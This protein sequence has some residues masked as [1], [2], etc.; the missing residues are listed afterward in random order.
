[1][2]VFKIALSLVLFM[3]I[4]TSA[5]AL[6]RNMI[7]IVPT[8]QSLDVVCENNA[9]ANVVQNSAIVT[10]SC[11][12]IVLPTA[13]PVV[14]ADTPT[15]IAP[16]NT[17]TPLPVIATDT[18]TP[19]PTNT[20]IPATATETPTLTSTPVIVLPSP[21]ATQ[22]A[23]SL[24]QYP[25]CGFHDSNVWHGL[26]DY[27]NQCH[28]NHTHDVNPNA[29]QTTNMI[30]NSA[31]GR[32]W[33]NIESYTGKQI[34]YIWQTTNENL[35]K[36]EG[37]HIA[38]AINLPCEQQNYLYLPE[39]ARNCISAFRGVFHSANATVDGVS[40]FHSYSAE[41]V[42]KDRLTGQIG[43]FA[44]GGIGDTDDAHAPYKTTCVNILGAN[45][46]PC[47]DNNTVWLN[48][49][50]NPPYWAFTVKNTALANL[51][52]GYLCRTSA[53]ES[54]PSNKM[55][56]EN[57]SFDRTDTLGNRMGAANHIFHMNAR[58]YS[59]SAAFDPAT[60]TFV[61]VCPD[62]SC[63]ATGDSF[64]VY[65]IVI[66][67]PSYLDADKNG[68]V[69]SYRGY[70]DR[71]GNIDKVGRCAAV[72]VEC[73]PLIVENMRV[74]SYVYDMKAPFLPGVRTW[75]D[76]VVTNEGQ[77]RYFDLTPKTLPKSWIA[78]K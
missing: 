3:T 46:S 9:L 27:V 78:I 31:T 17:E 56:W 69:E 25:L 38:S 37:Y 6:S 16:T 5:I 76:G 61:T 39:S 30:V 33:G 48:Q 54:L 28:Y 77:V 70:T 73:V 52:N 15:A 74:G 55:I 22:I 4:T 71:A 8:G 67:V 60:R 41:V 10:I 20:E 13:T 40:R 7:T 12:D 64:F 63:R 29:P 23:L 34:G 59:A 14:I 1:M 11:S 72:D 18:V 43:Y 62:G 49:L 66:D 35:T 44:T 36:H 21:T 42:T 2:K 45:R 51:A 68:W 50:N 47:P 75:G 32:T 26:I 65:A 24:E 57:I 53:C 58:Q 19:I